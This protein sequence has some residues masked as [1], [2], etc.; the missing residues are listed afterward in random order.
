MR[1]RAIRR[2]V[3][4]MTTLATAVAVVGFTA[5]GSA[6]ASTSTSVLVPQPLCTA[7]APGHRSCQAIRLV[8]KQVS[9]TQ[10]AQWRAEGLARPA[11]VTALADG[12]A[13][14][15]SPN[16]V[17]KAYGLNADGATTQTVAIVDAFDDPTAITDLNTFDDQY[18][19]PH[20]TSTSFQIVNQDGLDSP[21]PAPDAGWAG[22][23]TLDVQTVRGLCHLCKI[24]L[25]EADSSSFADLG[26]AVNRAVTMGAKIVS[27]SY[28]G[29]E[30]GPADPA[31]N[32]PGVAILASS[33]DDGWYGWDVINE[34]SFSANLPLSPASFNSV[35]AVGG[36]A[37]Y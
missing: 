36:T 28:G 37:L 35:T 33:G 5:P 7:L 19:L 16:Q 21:L 14:G 18:G 22:E 12:P 9:S 4:A 23:I 6:G 30:S 10:A 31:Y 24:L 32:H 1:N 13:G 3:F 25:V 26:T 11:A 34:L 29:F 17:A 2:S 20:E 8:T 15:Y 27:N